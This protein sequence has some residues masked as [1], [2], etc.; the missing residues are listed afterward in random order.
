M[1]RNM[2]DNPA[3]AGVVV[4]FRDVTESRRAEEALRDSEVNFRAL[5]ETAFNVILIFQGEH[6]VYANPA[7]MRESGYGEEELK[8]M[9]FW[10]MIHLD[11]K[12]MVRERGT[13]RLRGKEA[14]SG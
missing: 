14:P 2:L 9:R 8:S 6:L 13:D 12:D 10:D 1:D 7:A 3:V 11:F 5:A 4:N